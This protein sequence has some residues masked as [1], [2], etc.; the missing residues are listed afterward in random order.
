[1]NSRLSFDLFRGSEAC[2]SH[3]GP[4]SEKSPTRKLG[5]VSGGRMEERGRPSF[6]DISQLRV[7]GLPL[8]RQCTTPL[9]HRI[10][11]RLWAP[12]PSRVSVRSWTGAT[13]C[14]C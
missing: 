11:V 5:F 12:I 2:R 3:A 14:H 1:M 8:V 4:L 6:Y 10:E 9:G 7:T 13:T